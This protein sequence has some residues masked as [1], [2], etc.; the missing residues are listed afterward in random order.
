MRVAG[1]N[2]KGQYALFSMLRWW[3]RARN[4]RT[5]VAFFSVRSFSTQSGGQVGFIGLGNMGKAMATNIIAAR[6]SA[7]V[8][9]V[10]PQSVQELVAKGAVAASSP[11]TVVQQATIVIT[12]LPSPKIVQDVYLGDD[13]LISAAPEGTMLVDCSTI[14]PAT[15]KR[16]ASECAAQKLQFVDAPV[17][18]GVIGAANATLTF[19]AGGN[20]DAVKEAEKTLA[21]MGKSVVHCGDSGAGQAAKLC[22]NLLLGITM[23]AVCEAMHLGI[24]LG[25]DAKVL[26]QVINSSSGRSWSSDTYNPCPGVEMTGVPSTRDYEGGFACD[27]MLKDLNLAR[28]AASTVDLNMPLASSAHQVSTRRP[29]AQPHVLLPSHMPYVYALRIAIMRDRGS[30]TQS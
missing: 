30:F 3:N 28:D 22:N 7:V 17:S 2:Y 21:L 25:V 11:A 12:M 26:A 27:L 23:G 6:G 19:M 5:R 10:N 29:S 16:V 13:G 15:A 18:G 8:F 14:D 24:R 20:A 4:A 1:T 9:D